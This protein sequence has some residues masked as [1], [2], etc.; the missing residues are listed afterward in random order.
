MVPRDGAAR[1][2]RSIHVFRPGHIIFI[3]ISL[4][5]ITL[6]LFV[7]RRRKP[8]IEQ[9]IRAFLPVA[10]AC[11]AIKLFLTI[12][13]VPLVDAVVVDGQLIYQETGA[14]SPYLES[15]HL[16]FELC[17]LQ[18]IFMAC[19]LLV[20]DPAWKRRL[21]SVIYGTA[22]V[23]G[24]LALILSSIAPEFET[25]HAFLTSP[26]AWEFFIYHSMIIV[27]ALSIALDETCGL[28]FGDIRWVGCAIV[29][30]DYISLYLNSMLSVPVYQEGEI[31][32]LTYALNFLSSYDD[33]IGL[34]LSDKPRYL[35]YFA[36]RYLIGAVLLALAYLPFLRRRPTTTSR[37]G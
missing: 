12:Q 25:T 35:A 24:L 3:L 31:K 19:T 2:T 22:L 36:A 21:Y 20:R 7:V 4:V 30:L 32:G 37:E 16:P 10:V 33:P 8:T 28:R 6:G 1:P 14:F 29:V 13:I 27:L 15:E 23:G 26:R 9:L 17:S 34:T 5:L 11:E 18:I